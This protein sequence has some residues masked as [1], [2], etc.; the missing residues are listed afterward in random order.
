MQQFISE[1]LKG[2][3]YKLFFNTCFTQ[4][5]MPKSNNNMEDTKFTKLEDLKAGKRLIRHPSSEYLTKQIHVN[6][7]RSV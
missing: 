6:E 5:E 2:L 7:L 1:V 3:P 4:N